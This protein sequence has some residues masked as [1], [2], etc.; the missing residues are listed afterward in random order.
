ML[1]LSFPKV[2]E[3]SNEDIESY[4]VKSVI[5]ATLVVFFGPLTPCGSR[6]RIFPGS[7]LLNFSLYYLYLS[8]QQVLEKSDGWIKVML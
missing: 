4:D 3:K 2:S 8:F 6:R 1:V 7:R 5:F